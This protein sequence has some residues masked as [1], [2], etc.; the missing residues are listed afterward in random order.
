MT[1]EEKKLILLELYLNGEI[2]K[3][4]FFELMRKIGK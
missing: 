3:E 4:D 1:Y 2:D